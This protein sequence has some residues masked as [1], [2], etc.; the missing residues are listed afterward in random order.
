[1]NCYIREQIVLTTREIWIVTWEHELL[2]SWTDS[3]YDS[4][5]MD[6]NMRTWTVIF[7]NR[8]C[9]ISSKVSIL[10]TTG[11]LCFFL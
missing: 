3:S 4:W 11:R 9:Y 8:D 5:D 7:V 1:M 2:Y 10:L 6:W